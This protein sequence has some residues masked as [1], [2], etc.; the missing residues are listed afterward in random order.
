MGEFP[1]REGVRRIALVDERQGRNEVGVCEV[2]I[3]PL[4]L[5]GEKKPLVDD[6]ARGER[7]DVPVLQLLLN[8]APDDEE[9]MLVRTADEQ[10]ADPRQDAARNRADGFW[11]DWN[12]TPRDDVRP[13][14]SDSRLEGRLLADGTEDHGDAVF[15]FRGKGG[16]GLAKEGVGNLQEEAGAVASL[17]VVPRCAAMHEPLQNRQAASDDVMGGDIVKVRD[18]ADAAGVVFK[19][20]VIHTDL[21]VLLHNESPSYTDKQTPCQAE[22][23]E[24]RTKYSTMLEMKPSLFFTRCKSRVHRRYWSSTDLP[25]SAYRLFGL[26]QEGKRFSRT[27]ENESL[28][29]P[30]AISLQATRDFSA[31][32]PRF[33]ICP[34]RFSPKPLKDVLATFCL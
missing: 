16:D 23:T 11:N 6:R 5:W 33:L 21:S 26:P 20:T 1:G 12:V 3:E 15:A 17:G 30:S 22:E 31:V 27:G 25:A 28:N 4:D 34:I 7:A 29:S 8:R 24:K 19:G 9:P 18:E 32:P 2:G 10:L 14:L 13:V